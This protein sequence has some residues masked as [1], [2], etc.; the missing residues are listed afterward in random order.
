MILGRAASEQHRNVEKEPAVVI[1]D[2][3]PVDDTAS[4]PSRDDDEFGFEIYRYG[5][6]APVPSLRQ[7]AAA[8]VVARHVDGHRP[9]VR[10]IVVTNDDDIARAIVAVVP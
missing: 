8:I 2:G 10:T 6:D 7:V 4:I 9:I 3:A 1:D 5:T